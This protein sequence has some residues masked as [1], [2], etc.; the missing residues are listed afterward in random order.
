MVSY[1]WLTTADTRISG[2]PQIMVDLTALKNKIDGTTYKLSDFFNSSTPKAN[3]DFFEWSVSIETT[4][5]GNG[6]SGAI[7]VTMLHVLKKDSPINESYSTVD[8]G[9]QA[10]GSRAN[11]WV[12]AA[13]K[14]SV[15]YLE[16]GASRYAYLTTNSVRMPLKTTQK[17]YIALA[18]NVNT[19]Y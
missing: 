14:R 12:N 8:Y 2:N 1:E 10:A 17:L 7:W 4:D 15:I 19:N 11:L 13:E 16:A 5:V 9:S 3:S 6:W 18:K